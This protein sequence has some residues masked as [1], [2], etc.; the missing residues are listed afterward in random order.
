M[1]KNSMTRSWHAGDS[2]HRPLQTIFEGCQWRMPVG[3]EFASS[4][5]LWHK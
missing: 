2:G 4:A 5:T 3:Y 1:N